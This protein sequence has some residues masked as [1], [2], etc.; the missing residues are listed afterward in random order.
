[1]KL[2]LLCSMILCPVAAQTDA[3]SLAGCRMF[4]SNNVW[5]A[6][7]STLPAAARSA[8]YVASIG[9]DR[10]LHPDFGPAGIG[11]P[12]AV[13]SGTQAKV[14]VSFDYADESDAA[15]YPIAP[16]APIEGGSDSTG[17]RHVLV[18]D[19]DNCVLFELFSAYPQSD[20]SWKAGSGAIFDLNDNALRPAGWTSTDAAG[21]P[22]L[23]GLV[24]YDEVASGQ[25][26]HA[27][28]FTAPKTRRAYIWPARHFASS[29]T[30]PAYAPM[31]QRFRLKAT[32]DT[33]GF[34]PDAQ[35]VLQALKAYGMILADNGSSWFISGAPDDRWNS[36]T[37][38]TLTRVKG[39]D[40]EAIDESALQ[41][42]PNSARVTP[43]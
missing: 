4:P 21:L 23:P 42:I 5:N 40:F 16:D 17:D 18:L 32:F 19:S 20:G 27:I 11:I 43:Q 12:F 6:D 25:I 14:S 34:P 8:D 29:I 2:V 36:D 37:L 13:V 38:H 26:R 31:G 9:A 35:V 24:R 10:P 39:F 15:G 28:R 1:M 7:I 22:V 30:D 33:S 41:L 3:P